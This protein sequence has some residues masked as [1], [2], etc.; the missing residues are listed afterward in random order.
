MESEK[1]PLLHPLRNLV[2]IQNYWDPN[3]KT[4][5]TPVP[6]EHFRGT[7]VKPGY[8][9]VKTIWVHPKSETPGSYSSLCY[10]LHRVIP[11]VRDFLE[12]RTRI[13]N[14]ILDCRFFDDLFSDQHLSKEHFNYNCEDFDKIL[15]EGKVP[16]DLPLK[17]TREGDFREEE[18]RRD[19]G[20]L[21]YKYKATLKTRIKYFD[22]WDE[23]GEPVLEIL[24][25][26]VP[27]LSLGEEFPRRRK[28]PQ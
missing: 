22:N 8:Y 23:D 27:V 19:L 21:L 5:K 7:P 12:R 14:G 11:T 4:M 2:L 3:E 10:T 16:S 17:V 24:R 18:F 9:L 28:N 6:W 13:R 15:L 26:G 1:R 25:K 20:R